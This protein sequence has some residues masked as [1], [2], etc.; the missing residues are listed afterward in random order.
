MT[1][2]FYVM[3]VGLASTTRLHFVVPS[4]FDGT[5]LYWSLSA[6]EHVAIS[7]DSIDRRPAQELCCRS[8]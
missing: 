4:G 2:T 1:V 6:N 8:R 7:V 5:E 3:T